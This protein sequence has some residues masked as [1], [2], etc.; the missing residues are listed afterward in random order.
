MFKC[1][2]LLEN[3]CKS[4]YFERT[5][6]HYNVTVSAAFRNPSPSDVTCALPLDADFI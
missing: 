3:Y 6:R 2:W 1:M 4:C 5:A